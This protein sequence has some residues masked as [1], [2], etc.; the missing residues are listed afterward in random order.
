LAVNWLDLVIALIVV[1]LSIAGLKRGF[2]RTIFDFAAVLLALRATDLAYLSVSK[3]IH[4]SP[5]P[6]A[7]VAWSYSVVFVVL[8]VILLILAKL[9]Y[10]TTLISLDTF[11]PAL[12]LLLGFG[13]AIA[14]GHAFA[15]IAFLATADKTGYSELVRQSTLAAEFYSFETYH[16][17]IEAMK[18]LGT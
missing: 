15:K 2:G 17:V 13:M 18:R 3:S 6:A 8:S 11:D 10:D 12:G 7:N 4:F 5:A 9:I 16:R 14:A 1:V